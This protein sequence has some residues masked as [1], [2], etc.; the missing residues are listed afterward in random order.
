MSF[1]YRQGVAGR[2]AKGIANRRQVREREVLNDKEPHVQRQV[3]YDVH[4]VV[5]GSGVV[6]ISS[7]FFYFNCIKAA[8]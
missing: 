3:V 4:V 8:Y 5:G 6:P 2:R 7:T 1:R